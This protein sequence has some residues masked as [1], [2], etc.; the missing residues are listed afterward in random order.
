MTNF[1]LLSEL[2][3]GGSEMMLNKCGLSRA[4]Q[5]NRK[6]KKPLKRDFILYN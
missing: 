3:E 2:L 4:G 5:I 6:N 1:K